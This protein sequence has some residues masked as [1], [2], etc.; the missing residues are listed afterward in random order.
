MKERID[1]RKLEMAEKKER[2]EAEVLEKVGDRAFLSFL[3][4]VPARSRK[5]RVTN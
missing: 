2:E 4:P 5:R 3:I 1:A